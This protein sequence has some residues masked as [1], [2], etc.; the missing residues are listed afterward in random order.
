MANNFL[1]DIVFS[2]GNC[3]VVQRSIL[4]VKYGS[5]KQSI[6]EVKSS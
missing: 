4:G 2:G 3:V 1:A 6:T 5:A